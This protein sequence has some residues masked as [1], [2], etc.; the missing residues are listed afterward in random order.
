[1]LKRQ[2]HFQQNKTFKNHLRANSSDKH[3]QS[4]AQ[5]LQSQNDVLNKAGS[6][7]MDNSKQLIF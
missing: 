3:Q 5:I 6:S 7:K 1:M 4:H 2:L